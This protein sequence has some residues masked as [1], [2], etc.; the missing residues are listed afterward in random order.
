MAEANDLSVASTDQTYVPSQNSNPNPLTSW[1]PAR[2][3]VRTTGTG[4]TMANDRA[5]DDDQLR[6]FLA[7]PPKA[8]QRLFSRREQVRLAV[9]CQRAL[10][11][12]VTS[13]DVLALTECTFR[14]YLKP[15]L[16]DVAVFDA[17]WTQV[18]EAEDSPADISQLHSIGV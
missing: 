8:M 12:K 18:L 3:A 9:R 15:S 6:W 2:A 1:R 7:L 14:R 17:A 5:F 10:E 16:D 11:S 4:L 13:T